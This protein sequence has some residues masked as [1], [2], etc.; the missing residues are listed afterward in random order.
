MIALISLRI[1]MERTMTR[2]WT[3]PGVR[4]LAKDL[5]AEREAARAEIARL[6]EQLR[7]ANGAL[8]HIVQIADRGLDGSHIGV[9]AHDALTQMSVVE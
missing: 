8:V 1:K 2:K 7:I 6:T 9:Y 4:H 3:A 5:L